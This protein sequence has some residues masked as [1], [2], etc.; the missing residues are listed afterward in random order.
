MR[1]TNLAFDFDY[2][3]GKQRDKM[4]DL[5]TDD[6]MFKCDNYVIAYTMREF[7]L[8]R[9]HMC[10]YSDITEDL[11]YPYSK[12]IFITCRPQDIFRI[13]YIARHLPSAIK[14]NVRFFKYDEDTGEDVEI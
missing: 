6:Y 13:K 10:E 7:F 1:S 4:F 14:A 2:L 11:Y 8:K 5:L 3:Y 12:I 9:F